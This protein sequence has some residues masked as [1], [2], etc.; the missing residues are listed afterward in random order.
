MDVA[1]VVE[2]P[3]E[4]TA[5]M[6]CELLKRNGIDAFP[7]VSSGAAY[8]GALLGPFSPTAAG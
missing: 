5:Q 4:T 8:S 1:G 2:A 7:K 6:W 3:A